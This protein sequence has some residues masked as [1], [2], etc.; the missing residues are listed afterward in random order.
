MLLPKA[1]VAPDETEAAVEAPEAAV[2]TAGASAETEAGDGSV[3]L[4][5]TTAG[6]T[7]RAPA[8]APA[9]GPAVAVAHRLNAAASAPGV[10]HA[11]VVA[12]VWAVL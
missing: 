12:K 3:I 8:H 2:T 9:H 5:P 7:A 1:S 10:A 4:T 6:H 11:P